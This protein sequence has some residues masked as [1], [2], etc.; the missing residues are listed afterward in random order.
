MVHMLHPA[1][2]RCTVLLRLSFVHRRLQSSQVSPALARCN[3][4]LSCFLQG[5]RA[6]APATAG[7]WHHQQVPFSSSSQLQQ[8]Q[9][10][11]E[12]QD[13]QEGLAFEEIYVDNQA[14]HTASSSPSKRPQEQVGCYTTAPI[15]IVQRCWPR[16]W[17][18]LK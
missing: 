18:P 17:L 16:A 14:A 5:L 13:Q 6:A 11:A 15:C 8:Q 3:R 4:S 2:M 10:V 12:A 1:H 7:L 9:Q